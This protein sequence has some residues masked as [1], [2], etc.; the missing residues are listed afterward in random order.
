MGAVEYADM[1][2]RRG[3]EG[4]RALAA[5]WG[6]TEA[7]AAALLADPPEFRREYHARRT[8]QRAL[9]DLE[10]RLADSSLRVP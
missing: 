2:C 8:P 7:R 1:S 3:G 5:A 6:V 4:A 10:K 9:R